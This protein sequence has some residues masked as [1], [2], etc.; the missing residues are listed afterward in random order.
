MTEIVRKKVAV[1]R[2]NPYAVLLD[3]LASAL[4]YGQEVEVWSGRGGERIFTVWFSSSGKCLVAKHGKPDDITWS[5]RRAYRICQRELR[6]ER[7][8]REEAEERRA[9]A[10]V[11]ASPPS[12][13][14]RQLGESFL[15]WWNTKGVKAYNELGIGA[16][17]VYRRFG[18]VG[19]G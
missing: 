16:D 1:G 12:K 13:Y 9:T 14:Q 10:R 15:S 17:E 2:D 4:R 19:R 5:A 18:K 11:S 7:R 6:R 3:A 8:L